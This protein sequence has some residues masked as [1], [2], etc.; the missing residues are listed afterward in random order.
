M[1]SVS[2]LR[3]ITSRA[4]SAIIR[5]ST[6][7]PW[8]PNMRRTDTGPNSRKSSWIVSA[9]ISAASK[10]GY[11]LRSARENGSQN[12][13]LVGLGGGRI[14]GWRELH[15][16]PTATGRGL[17]RIIEHEGRGQLVD[18][19]IH[20]G[21]KQE[22]NG[23]RIDQ[24]FDALVLDHLIELRRVGRIFHRVGH[25]GTA[26]VLHDDT[27]ARERLVGFCHDRL[28]A[29]GGSVGEFHH[30]GSWSGGCHL[31]FQPVLKFGES[32]IAE[33]PLLSIWVHGTAAAT[34]SP[35][36][37]RGARFVRHAALL[38]RRVPHDVDRD[39]ADTRDARHSVLHH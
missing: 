24:Q 27:D 4:T 8:P 31:F 38:P 21:A 32:R 7:M 5:P 23:L 13:L 28:D 25:A 16:L 37:Q 30:L 17:V 18:L 1:V 35:H 9:S 36:V 33:T 6:K 14:N 20:L 3:W 2:A 22:Q 15:R 10:S 34:I 11:R 29:I 39:R 26:A 19:E 12:A